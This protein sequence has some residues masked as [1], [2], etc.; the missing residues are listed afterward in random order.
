MKAVEAFLLVPPPINVILS[1]PNSAF[2]WEDW[3]HIAVCSW[4][5]QRQCR[6]AGRLIVPRYPD[7]TPREVCSLPERLLGSDLTL[8]DIL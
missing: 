5:S 8:T 3:R 1:G 6:N 2:L 7:S 4:G